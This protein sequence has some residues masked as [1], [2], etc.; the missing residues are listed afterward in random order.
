M[1]RESMYD[2]TVQLTKATGRTI[3]KMDSVDFAFRMVMY[4]K[5]IFEMAKW[6]GMVSNL[7]LNTVYSPIKS[8]MKYRE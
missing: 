5:E 8:I 3:F 6:M 7:G 4:S 2:Q 1:V